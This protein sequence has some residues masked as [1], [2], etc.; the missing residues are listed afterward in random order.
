MSMIRYSSKSIVK[1]WVKQPLDSLY[2]K[3]R[4]RCLKNPP[5]RL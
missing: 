2:W 3:L 1:H 4:G 5:L